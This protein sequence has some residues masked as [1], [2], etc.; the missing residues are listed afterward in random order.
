[1]LAS[2]EP[3]KPILLSIRYHHEKWSGE[4]YPHG[5][6]GTD[7]PFGA[8]V[9]AVVDAFHAMTSDRPYRKALSTDTAFRILRE[10]AGKQ[11]DPMVVDAF[12]DSSQRGTFTAL[13]A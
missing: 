2:V 12:L 8:R 3:L 5:L 1:M 4:G 6:S 9:V 7:I 10:Q 13:S 11:F